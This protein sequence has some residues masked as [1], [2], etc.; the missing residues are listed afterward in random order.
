MALITAEG[1]PN[2]RIFRITTTNDGQECTAI[3]FWRE[4]QSNQDLQTLEFFALTL[5][6]T[7]VVLDSCT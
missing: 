3:S 2:V 4:T 1:S 7:M 6:N 5:E